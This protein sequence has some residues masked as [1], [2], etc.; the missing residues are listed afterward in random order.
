MLLVTLL[1]VYCV[2]TVSSADYH[3]L[4]FYYLLNHGR[5]ELPEYSF[6]AMLDDYQIAYFDSTLQRTVPRQ[7]WMANS[8]Q[9][10]HWDA[11]AITMAG[12]HGLVKGNAEIFYRQRQGASSVFFVQG[13]CGCEVMDDN[14]T[15]GFIK[16]GYGGEDA[17]VFDKDTTSWMALNPEFRALA[18]R[19]NANSFMNKYFKAL[20][21]KDCVKWLLT[22]VECGR[23]ALQR[24]ATPEVFIGERSNR[25]QVLRLSCL[26]TGFYPRPIDVTWLRNG[27]EVPD[28]ETSDLLPNQE[29][30]YRVM[31]TIELSGDDGERYSCHIEHASLLQ[32]LDVPWERASQGGLKVR[33]MIAAAAISLSLLAIIAGIGL[34]SKRHNGKTSSNKQRP[35]ETSRDWQKP[36]ETGRNQQRLADT[37]RDH[38]R[39]AETNRD[40]QKLAETTGT[41]KDQQRLTE[42][43]IDQQRLAETVKAQQRQAET[44]RNL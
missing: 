6:V 32:G 2:P 20:L 33:I 4:A 19:W 35:S 11:M 34:W 44:G 37:N 29:E 17:Y 42:T 43:N 13:M 9:R 26:V 24:R 7:R 3:I 27:Q 25:E 40:Q 18:E 5:A 10:D 1:N 23:G 8:F 41:I 14:S 31:K 38:Q 15:D 22:Y 30:T 39:P 36:A 12:F 16:L 28:V 21:E